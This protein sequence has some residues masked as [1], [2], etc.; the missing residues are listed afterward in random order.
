MT[1]EEFMD[2][3]HRQANEYGA[4]LTSEQREIAEQ[5][6][7]IATQA[8]REACAKACDDEAKAI[9]RE[10]EGCTNAQYD[11]M[12]DGAERC[13]ETLRSNGGNHRPPAGGP[14]D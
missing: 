1:L 7:E 14:V 12:A 6:W 8:A 5:A 2:E 9:R 11:W 13:A 3:W 4:G 10:G